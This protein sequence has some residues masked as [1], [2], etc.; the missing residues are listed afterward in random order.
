MTVE[1]KYNL[2]QNIWVINGNKIRERKITFIEW[3]TI[4]GVRYH[5]YVGDEKYNNK[6][7]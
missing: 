1:T 3:D 6:D 4:N 7:C 2:D 5:V